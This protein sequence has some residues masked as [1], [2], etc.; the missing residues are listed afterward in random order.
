MD[1][2]RAPH[3]ETANA[4]QQPDTWR[5][6]HVPG[7]GIRETGLLRLECLGRTDVHLATQDPQAWD[8]SRLRFLPKS[9][10]MKK[11]HHYE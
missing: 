11:G 1:N 8:H 4:H 9:A 5:D 2:D 10:A 6:L 3:H 7:A